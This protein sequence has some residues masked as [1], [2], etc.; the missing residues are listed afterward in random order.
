MTVRF[1]DILSLGSDCEVS[2]QLRR[3]QIAHTPS[4]FDWLITPWDALIRVLHDG[5]THL[6][7]R[8]YPGYNG[9]GAVCGTYELVYW[10]EFARDGSGKVCVTRQAAQS[11]QDKLRHKIDRMRRVMESDK[12]VLFVRAGIA[13]DAP[14]DR[15]GFGQA[16]PA[17]RLNDFTALVSRLFPG[18][19]FSLLFIEYAGRD[20]LVGHAPLDPRIVHHQMTCPRDPATGR[21]AKPDDAEWDGLFARI[22]Y[23][24]RP[25]VEIT[26]SE[27]LF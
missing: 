8:I 13:T 11:V 23:D 27:L 18:L 10:H 16:F 22:G 17:H 3:M 9:A 6:C 26:A 1:D 5:G 15:Y 2:L 12:T 7:N 24:Y 19:R 25:A 14:G 20:R 4:V 21:H